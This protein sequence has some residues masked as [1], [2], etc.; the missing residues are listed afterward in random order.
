M[1]KSLIIPKSKLFMMIMNTEDM[2]YLTCICEAKNK[3]YHEV[4]EACF[5]AG[6]IMLTQSTKCHCNER[7]PHVKKE[8]Q[9][10]RPEEENQPT[11]T[12]LL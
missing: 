8:N 3:N 5:H 6:L 4:V 10:N 11:G 9:E 12:Q 2:Q 1:T 7:K